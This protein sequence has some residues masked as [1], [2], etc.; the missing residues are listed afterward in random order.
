MFETKPWVTQSDLDL[1]VW[2]RLPLI[3]L[4]FTQ[5]LEWP[6]VLPHTVHAVLRTEPR[7]RIL[8]EHSTN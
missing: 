8:G 4:T 2:L 3:I 5:V 7:A 6:R 1:T